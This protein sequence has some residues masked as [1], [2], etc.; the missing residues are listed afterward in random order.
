MALKDASRLV[1]LLAYAMQGGNSWDHPSCKRCN[2]P[3]AIPRKRW[4]KTNAKGVEALVASEERSKNT[5]TTL[6]THKDIT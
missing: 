3:I 4:L 6:R 1:S 2:A 5:K